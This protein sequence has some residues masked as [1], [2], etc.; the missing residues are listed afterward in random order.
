[1]LNSTECCCCETSQRKIEN[2]RLMVYSLLMLKF[3]ARFWRFN[4]STKV[5]Y[6]SALLMASLPF[7]HIN[8]LIQTLNTYVCECVCVWSFTII[9]LIFSLL[10]EFFFWYLILFL[11]I[12]T[13]FASNSKNSHSALHIY[14]NNLD[15][16]WNR[17]K[18]AVYLIEVRVVRSIFFISV[19]TSN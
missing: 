3:D 13:V 8:I 12:F 6:F 10:F 9:L 15:A 5:L 1:M 19:L 17:F 14:M 4:K 11:S 18:F 16:R 7:A 2:Y